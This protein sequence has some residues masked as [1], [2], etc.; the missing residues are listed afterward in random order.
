MLLKQ[1]L[2]IASV[3]LTFL[4][5]I[6]YFQS[7]L[8]KKTKP[9]LFSW[10]IWTLVAGIVFVAQYMEGAGPGC[11]M[12]GFTTLMCANIVGFAMM[13][14]EKNITRG[15]WIAFVSGLAAII[16]WKL[17]KDPLW[18]VIIVSLGKNRRL[19]T[20]CKAYGACLLSPPWRTT[21]L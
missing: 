5:Y 8:R 1:S 2:G 11:W 4:A 14:G 9:H 3:V 18:A 15:D 19:P 12:A 6:P 13:R 20:G 17:T 21:T 10:L 7:L 16:L